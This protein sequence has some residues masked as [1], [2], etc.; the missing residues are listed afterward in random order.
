MRPPPAHPL[1][2]SPS[3][4]LTEG[5][6]AAA[7]GGGSLATA[8]AMATATSERGSGAAQKCVAWLGCCWERNHCWLPPDATFSLTTATAPEPPPALKPSPPALA[9]AAAAAAGGGGG[10]VSPWSLRSTCPQSCACQLS[11]AAGDAGSPCGPPPGASLAT[12]T[13]SPSEP[14]AP[15]SALSLLL[16]RPCGAQGALGGT[17]L[18]LPGLWKLFLRPEGQPRKGRAAQS[19]GCMSM[20][21]ATLARCSAHTG[22]R[23][24]VQSPRE[25]ASRRGLPREATGRP[26]C[27]RPDTPH[28][29]PYLPS[30]SPVSWVQQGHSCGAPAP[31]LSTP[32][33]PHRNLRKAHPTAGTEGGAPVHALRPRTLSALGRGAREGGRA[34]AGGRP[35]AGALAGA[36]PG[37]GVTPRASSV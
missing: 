5:S 27:A 23:Y 24:Q 7:A 28:P 34:V 22:R 3:R 33:D 17:L 15:P 36:P 21:F 26:A 6:A 10:E 35:G 32:A 14:A 20:S 19:R 16:G 12:P 18:R 25:A 30:P 13:H 1:L 2:A 11:W 29:A 4:L 8:S 37:L 9:A 31:P